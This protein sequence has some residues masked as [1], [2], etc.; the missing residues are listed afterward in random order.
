MNKIKVENYGISIGERNFSQSYFGDSINNMKY[1]PKINKLTI[2]I[3]ILNIE[4]TY[5]PIKSITEECLKNL[6]QIPEMIFIIKPIHNKLNKKQKTVDSRKKTEYH[7][8]KDLIDLEKMR[9]NLIK[10]SYEYQENEDL[11][12]WDSIISE[13]EKKTKELEEKLQIIK[14]EIYAIEGSYE[15]PLYYP[16]K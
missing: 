6:C 1:D 9:I 5:S 13:S 16:I 8:I 15:F 3:E 14:K 11:K 2:Y 4:G 12:Y 7:D 10:E